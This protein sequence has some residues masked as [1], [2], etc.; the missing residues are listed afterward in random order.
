MITTAFVNI[1]NKR[2][3]AIAWDTATGVGSFEFEP[4]FLAQGLDLSPNVV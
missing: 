1:W 2:V 4:S 3:G